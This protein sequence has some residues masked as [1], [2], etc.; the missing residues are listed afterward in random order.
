MKISIIGAGNVGALAAM[1]VA[2]QNLGEVVL[3]DI[4]KG[5]AQG[6]AY[7]L[8]DC[9]AILG[10]HYTIQGSSLIE[11]IKG[12]DI[13]VI[14]A[15]LARKPGMTRED[16]ISK[17]ADIVGSVSR[18]IKEYAPSSIV[19]VVTNPLDVMTYLA[20]QVTGFDKRKVFGMGLTLDASRFSNLIAHEFGAA[21]TDI[22]P[23]VIGS[24]GE[25]MMPLS[26]F[27]K[28]KGKTLDTLGTVE[29]VNALVERTKKRGQ[30][31]VSLLG[32]GSAFFA[33]SAAIAEIVR[34]VA[35]GQERLLGV[36]AFLDGEYGVKGICVGV[37]CRLGRQGIG[38]IQILDLNSSEK[39]AFLKSAESIRELI[40][41][42]THY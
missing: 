11:D 32:S 22:E 8:D 33:P 36:S 37:P 30:E 13:V 15:G 19:V 41:L 18:A 27:T 10:C 9:R 29:R 23:C 4:L 34:V 16:L 7:D 24:H 35:R 1:R 3:I 25:T 5:A 17:N 2:E 20:L 6:K 31:I 40:K 26:R 28:I 42:L 38:N 39:E 21:V 14:T 12:S